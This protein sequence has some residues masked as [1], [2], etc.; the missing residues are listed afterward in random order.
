[1]FFKL[2]II[3]KKIYFIYNFILEK[4]LNKN[5]KEYSQLLNKNLI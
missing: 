5:T 1:M 2:L 4:I 3:K